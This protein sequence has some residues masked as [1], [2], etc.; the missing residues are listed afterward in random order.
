V[1]YLVLIW[2]RDDSE[3]QEKKLVEAKDDMDLLKKISV[4]VGSRAT[5]EEMKEEEEQ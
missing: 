3:L 4:P 5:Y 2:R 1:K